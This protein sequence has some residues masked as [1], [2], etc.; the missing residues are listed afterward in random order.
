VRALKL[1]AAL[2]LA[3]LLHLVGTRLMPSLPLRLDVFLV[4]VAL[5]ALEGVTLSAVLF[6]LLVGLLQDTLTSGPFG[7]FG[8]ADTAVAY[9]MARLAQRLVIQRA[10]GVFA[11]VCFASLSQQ[12]I[13]AALAFLLLPNPS[14]PA[15]V[16]GVT[17]VAVAASTSS[18]ARR[19]MIWSTRSPSIPARIAALISRTASSHWPRRLVSS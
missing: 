15:P 19:T 5:Q 6:G 18:R 10:S 16:A 3:V 2:V 1:V 11:V 7:L 8:F 13:L 4:I 9:G 17:I 14:L 12:V